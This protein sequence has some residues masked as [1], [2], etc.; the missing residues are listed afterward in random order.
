LLLNPDKKARFIGDEKLFNRFT[1]PEN[2][3]DGMVYFICIIEPD[4]SLTHD[5]GLNSIGKT[6]C[7]YGRSYLEQLTEWEP[8]IKDGKPVRSQIEIT[9]LT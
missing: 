4:G 8:A 7:D 6:N 1:D 3:C 2:G 9:I 5:E